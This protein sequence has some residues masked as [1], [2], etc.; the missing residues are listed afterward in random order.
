MGCDR[1]HVEPQ[2]SWP[3]E[4]APN[5]VDS[6]WKEFI[7]LAEA[8]LGEK[9]D[10]FGRDAAPYVGRA[11]LPL[12]KQCSLNTALKR[13]LI[14]RW[15]PK[16]RAWKSL[17]ALSRAIATAV[18]SAA[19]KGHPW[20]E[21]NR[22]RK[23]MQEL[24]LA[25]LGDL[26][27]LGQT[28][29]LAALSRQ[30]AKGR[31]TRRKDL[32]TAIASLTDLAMKRSA[33]ASMIGWSEWAK[34][35]VQGSAKAAFNFVKGP[36]RTQ[37]SL[38]ADGAPDAGMRGF[39]EFASK[40]I[41]LWRQADSTENPQ[42]WE[43][44]GP[45]LRKLTL[46]DLDKV[47]G[48]YADS[49]GLGRDGMHPRSY[50]QLPPSY[51]RRL[52]GILGAWERDAQKPRSWSNLIVF[53]DKPQGGKRPIGQTVSPL[54]VWSRMRAADAASWERQSANDSF[55]W[56][57]VGRPCDQ[58]AWNHT[59]LAEYGRETGADVATLY[60]D[61]LKFYELVSHKVLLREAKA[62]GFPLRLLKPLLA[63]YAGSRVLTVGAL[64]IEVQVKS[65]I[66]AGCSCAT[67]LAKVLL[68]RLL[69]RLAAPSLHIKN[70]VDD[71]TIQVVGK[72]EDVRRKLGAAGRMLAAGVKELELV[73]SDDNMKYTASSTRLA[74]GL[75]GQWAGLGYKRAAWARILGGEGTAGARRATA[76]RQE[77]RALHQK[78]SRHIAR[79]RRAGAN[80][81]KLQGMSSNAA[82]V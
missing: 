73:L 53:Q 51:R 15:T 25:D 41:D 13:D 82:G 61:L 28:W 34:W 7:G 38:V 8:K 37:D 57:T 68:L 16:V 1:A 24:P 36:V 30:L 27:I 44:M 17:E 47:L 65:T 54:R 79:L 66:L 71:I 19:A 50:L 74:R 43:D 33:H 29:S 21:V 52:L 4:E 5:D 67:T 9:H 55:F 62:V 23:K 22:L 64:A 69:R 81:D 6:A 56:G 60:G 20:K 58:A 32:V 12:V 49:V 78:R 75:A 10:L 26:V 2:W 14:L 77:R 45:P 70:V 72:F 42:D 35:A 11:E 80:V 59:V 39:S 76:L 18:G 46:E 31:V 48:T 40:W 63:M 3:L